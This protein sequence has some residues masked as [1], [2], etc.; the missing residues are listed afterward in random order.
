MPNT[1]HIHLWADDNSS[2]KNR[3]P[4]PHFEVEIVQDLTPAR[5]PGS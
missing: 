5:L 3:K 4:E 1:V 2:G